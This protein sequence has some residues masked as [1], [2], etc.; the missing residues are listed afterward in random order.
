MATTQPSEA[1][2]VISEVSKQEGG[3]S[4]GSTAAQLQS[5][6]TKQRNLEDAAAQVGSKLETAPESITK[7]DASLLHSRESRAMGG[8]QPPKSSIASQAQSVAAANERGD[9]VQTNAQLNPGEQ[10]QLD[11]EANYM[12]QAD[13]VASKLA[14]DPSSVTKEDADKMHSRETRAF[15]ATESGGIA[16]QAQSQVAENTGA[17]N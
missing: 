3:P 5:E 8:Q 14:T 10:S 7:E 11:R 6:V 2:Q 15:G 12:Q 16:S 13:K 17:K 9:T 4:K 1:S